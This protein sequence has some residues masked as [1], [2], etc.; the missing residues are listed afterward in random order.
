M[1]AMEH[2]AIFSGESST[3]ILSASAKALLVE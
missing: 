1:P 3:L 2:E